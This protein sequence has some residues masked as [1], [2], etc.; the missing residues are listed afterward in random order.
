MSLLIVLWEKQKKI[1]SLLF[2]LRNMKQ[3]IQS[4]RKFPFFSIIK[5]T[6]MKKFIGI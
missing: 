6:C 1:T 3:V 2:F 5:G 4:Y